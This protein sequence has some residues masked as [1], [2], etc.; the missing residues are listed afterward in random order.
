MT[1]KKTNE[2]LNLENLDEVSG[3]T[4]I[5]CKELK[6]AL[7]KVDGFF[8]KRKPTEK[9]VCQ[10]LDKNIGVK[11]TLHD[12]F[13]LD[14]QTTRAT[15]T[16]TKTNRRASTSPTKKPCRRLKASSTDNGQ[17]RTKIP[18][19]SIDGIFFARRATLLFSCPRVKSLQTR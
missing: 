1:D 12:G 5:E 7:P 8:G 4:N 14:L 10:W 15:R 17:A 18:P 13:F 6:N 16:C 11:A 19:A 3:G 9:E 2:M